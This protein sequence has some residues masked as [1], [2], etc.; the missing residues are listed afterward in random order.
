[1]HVGLAV[2]IVVLRVSM[3][4]RADLQHS[5]PVQSLLLVQVLGQE[6]AQRPLQQSKPDDESQSAE[7]LQALGQ[8]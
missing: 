3:R 2:K 5:W 7:V 6:E 8:V 1:M 4:V